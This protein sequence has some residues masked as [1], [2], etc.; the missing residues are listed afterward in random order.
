V[1]S[2]CERDLYS[3]KMNQHAEYLGQRSFLT[4]TKRSDCSTWTSK[5]VGNRDTTRAKDVSSNINRT[6][7]AEITPP[8]AATEWSCLLLRDLIC[9]KR[10]PF[11]RCRGWWECTARFLSLWPL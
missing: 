8:P 1:T 7:A 5:V 11:R 4:Q 6:Q 3:V 2:T 10:V 9:S